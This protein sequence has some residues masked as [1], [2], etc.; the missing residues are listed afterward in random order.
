MK[1]IRS[2]TDLGNA[3]CRHRRG[4]WFD[5]DGH[6]VIPKSNRKVIYGQEG[7]RGAEQTFEITLRAI[8]FVVFFRDLSKTKWLN[9]SYFYASRNDNILL[10]FKRN[11]DN[12]FIPKNKRCSLIS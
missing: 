11:T 1:S 12:A 3:H 6:D 7:R 2:P 10:F 5:R 4:L 8:E 9:Y